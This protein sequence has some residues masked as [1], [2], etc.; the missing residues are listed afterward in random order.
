M[1]AFKSGYGT[2]LYFEDSEVVEELQEKF[3][4]YKENFPIW[5]QQ[6]SGM[7]QFAIWTA[8]EIEGF[9]ATLQHYNPL[10]DEEVRKEWGVPENWKLIAQMPFGK[11]VV[12][13][14]EKEYQPLENRVKFINNVGTSGEL[15]IPTNYYLNQSGFATYKKVNRDTTCSPFISSKDFLIGIFHL[16]F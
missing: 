12:P 6:S 7:L 15:F 10:I 16:I 2:V 8:L 4:L 1:N 13:A 14:G 11:P 5:S 3:A 9:G